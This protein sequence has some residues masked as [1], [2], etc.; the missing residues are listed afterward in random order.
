MTVFGIIKSVG[1]PHKAILED[2]TFVERKDLIYVPEYNEFVTVAPDPDHFV[3]ENAT[4]NQN[5][6]MCTCGS[7][8]VIAMPPFPKSWTNTPVEQ[9]HPMFVCL[10]YMNYGK[11]VTTYVNKDEFGKQQ[12][13]YVG[14]RGKSKKY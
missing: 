7:P 5:A 9:Q 8:A 11:H 13:V 2:G 10:S 14:E 6:Y 12:N 4:L 3:Y 1:T